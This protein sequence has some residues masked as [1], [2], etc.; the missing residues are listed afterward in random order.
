MS[1]V[2]L[3]VE[4]VAVDWKGNPIIVLRELSGR[5]KVF[6]WVGM[7]EAT[8]I[9][10]HLEGQDAPRPLTHDLIGLILTRLGAG[11]KQ[12]TI[13][14]M[15]KNTY[16]A[17]LHLEIGDRVETIDCRPSDAIAIALR[18]EAPILIDNDL[19]DT[20]DAARGQEAADLSP[21]ATVVD[22]GE[23]TVH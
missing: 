14:D 3:R 10:M 9:S 13:T 11:V 5:R 15:Q 23:P 18:A 21:E 12:T 2:E 17:E 6:I 8:A 19:L 4:A 22:S 1:M 16:Y 7:P 20:L